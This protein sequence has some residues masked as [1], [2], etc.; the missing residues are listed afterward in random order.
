MVSGLKDRLFAD[1]GTPEE[2]ARLIQS[3][4][5]LGD[6]PAAEAAWRRAIEAHSGD[7]SAVSFLTE[8]A[9]LAG[10]RTQ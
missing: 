10:V 2:W 7:R 5:V 3:Q 9:V 6:V 1:G 4:G 8:A